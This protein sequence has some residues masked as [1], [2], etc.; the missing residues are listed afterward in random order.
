MARI[1]RKPSSK[2]STRRASYK[3]NTYKPRSRRTSSF[4][5]FRMFTSKRWKL[6]RRFARN[7]RKRSSN[8]SK[9]YNKVI[10]KEFDALFDSKLTSKDISKVLAGEDKSLAEQKRVFFSISRSQDTA[11]NQKVYL[12]IQ[13]IMDSFCNPTSGDQTALHSKVYAKIFKKT[14]SMTWEKAVFY[15]GQKIIRTAKKYPFM[16]G[17]K[18]KHWLCWFM[19]I[20]S[21]TGTH[22]TSAGALFTKDLAVGAASTATKTYMNSAMYSTKY[23]N[24]MLRFA[25]RLLMVNNI[26]K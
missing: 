10:R 24:W 22:A 4:R 3:R 12:A 16:N 14:T 7:H 25:L 15:A 9:S 5:R 18:T 8:F 2:R 17:W 23:W 20:G 13:T 21:L 1:K 19:S 6:R 26:A 11:T